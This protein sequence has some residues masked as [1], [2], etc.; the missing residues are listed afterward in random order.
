MPGLSQ[1]PV[2]RARSLSNL[3]R[4]GPAPEQHNRRAVTHG[5]YAAVA[6]TRLDAKVR[7]VFD[8]LAQDAPLQEQGGGLPA[9]DTVAVMLLAKALCRLEDVETYLTTRGLL[10]G[11]DQQRPAV[12]LERRLRLEVAD[13]LD[14]MGMTPRARARLGLDLARG[15]DLA[16]AMSDAGDDDVID[17]DAA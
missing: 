2:K 10:D 15:F 3:Q 6:K 7:E 13:Y 9:A 8:A 5:A 11:D 14:A 4:G 1:D 12:D 16:T 17:G